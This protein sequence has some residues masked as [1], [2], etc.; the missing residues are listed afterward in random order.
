MLWRKVRM[1]RITL[2]GQK[3]AQD[4]PRGRSHDFRLPTSSAPERGSRGLYEAGR[5]ATDEAVPRSFIDIS[6]ASSGMNASVVARRLQNLA[7]V[8]FISGEHDLYFDWKDIDEFDSH[9]KAIHDALVGT[10][11]GYRVHTQSEGSQWSKPASWPPPGVETPEEN[12]AFAKRKGPSG[13]DR[14]G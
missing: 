6:F 4:R 5:A 9:I 3:W 14:I 2:S 8:T 12:P 11:A 10:G 13:V 1:S 7:H